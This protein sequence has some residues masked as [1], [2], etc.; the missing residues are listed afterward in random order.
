[1]GCDIH[2]YVE[3]TKEPPAQTGERHWR[4]FG[5]DLGLN[6]HYGIFAKLADV[7]NCKDWGIAPITHPRGLPADLGYT[8]GGDYW[9]FICETE[10]EGFC[11]AEKAEEWVRRGYARYQND[12]RKFVSDPD[13]HSA[14]WLTPDEWDAALKDPKVKDAPVAYRATAAAMRCLVEHGYEVR[15]VFWFD[16]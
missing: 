11:T 13:A 1:M 9:L 16:N 8:A 2:T 14:S 12:E 6:R 15:I 4:S 7:R 10:G 5:Q 3:Y